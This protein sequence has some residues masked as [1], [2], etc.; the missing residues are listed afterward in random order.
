MRQCSLNSLIRS[1]IDRASLFFRSFLIRST[2]STPTKLEE[3]GLIARTKSQYSLNPCTSR[4]SNCS[5]SLQTFLQLFSHL[6]IFCF[7]LQ[8]FRAMYQ[9]RT[10]CFQ[11]KVVGASAFFSALSRSYTMLRSLIS[12]RQATDVVCTMQLLMSLIA[13]SCF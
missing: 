11:P 7:L 12:G 1:I 13:C 5:A 6:S 4:S 3:I 2:S 8:T 9:L 10:S